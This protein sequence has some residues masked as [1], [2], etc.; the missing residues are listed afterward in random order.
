MLMLVRM[1]LAVASAALLLSTTAAL[2]Q[3]GPDQSSGPPQPQPAPN[4]GGPQPAPNYGAPQPQPQP[5]PQQQPQPQPQQYPQPQPQQYPQPQPYPQA[6]PQPYPAP[7]PQQY[8][9]PQ[10]APYPQSYGQ[11]AP[12]APQYAPRP[13]YSAQPYAQAPVGGLTRP[14]IREIKKP[15]TA[16]LLAVGATG[17]GLLTFFAAA[18]DNNEELALVGAG[19][20]LIGPS[21]GHIYA[22]ENGHAVKMSLL[23]TGAL[24]TFIYGAVKSTEGDCIDYCYENTNNEGEAAMYLGGAVFVVSTLYDLYDSGRAARRFNEKAARTLTVGPTMMSSAH[25]GTSPGVALSGSF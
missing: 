23:R 6:Q 17:L 13:Y 2:A 14:A 18:D 3:P 10:P 1:R 7:Y 4:Y 25:G 24:L 11:P 20:T 12:Y 22:G 5:Y 21:A 9:Q 8:P 16:Q 15:G 19:L